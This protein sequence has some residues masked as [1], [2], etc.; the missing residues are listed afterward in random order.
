MV[1]I[2]DAASFQEQS[3]NA[4]KQESFGQ[5]SRRPI[6]EELSVP[7]DLRGLRVFICRKG[8]ENGGIEISVRV[9]KRSLLIFSAVS[10]DGFVMLPDGTI[11]PFDDEKY[12]DED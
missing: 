10:E 3:I 5:L 1:R 6:R 4:L 9:E 8:G 2:F 12:D 11:V 7:P